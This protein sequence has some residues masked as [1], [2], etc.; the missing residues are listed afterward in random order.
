[1]RL[2]K[3]NIKYVKEL[4][5]DGLTYGWFVS[6]GSVS[7]SREFINYEAYD[8]MEKKNF[9]TI[10]K[11]YPQDLLPVSVRQFIADRERLVFT[12]ETFGNGGNYTEY[13]YK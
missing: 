12:S 2:T 13:I 7:D 5:M 1:M 3:S 11:E 10:C 4:T 9:K 6:L 8:C